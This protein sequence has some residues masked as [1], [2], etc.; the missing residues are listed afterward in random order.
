MFMTDPR[1]T[2][3]SHRFSSVPFI[4][5]VT[6]DC[7]LTTPL[8]ARLSGGWLWAELPE[9]GLFE[10][11]DNSAWKGFGAATLL[12]DRHDGGRDSSNPVA[13]RTR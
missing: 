8:A 5:P 13:M 7:T 6:Q 11:E 9:M 2:A 10:K 4:V 1:S 12:R 3:S